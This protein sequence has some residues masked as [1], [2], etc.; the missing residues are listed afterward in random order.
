MQAKSR[1]ATLLGL[2]VILAPCAASAGGQGAAADRVRWLAEHAVAVRSIAPADED[3]SDLMPLLGWI[4][5]ARVVALGEVTHG[6]G[7][8]FLAKARLIRFLHQEMAFDVIAWESGFFDVPLVDAALR[9]DVPLPEAA[10]R[11]LYKIWANS[12]EV[13]PTFAYVR[14][15]QSTAHPIRSAGFDCRVSTERSRAALFPASIFDFFD[16]LD[17]GLISKQERADLVAMSVGL[18]P[19]DYYEHPGERRYN[20]ALPRRLVSVID[21][22]RA[23]LLVR[24]SP[25]QIDSVRQSLVSFMNMDRALGGLA[26][27]GH[28]DNGYTRDRAMAENLLWL[29]DGPL[30]GHKVIV[31]AHNYHVLRDLPMAGASEELTKTGS[32]AGPMGMHL[33][34]ALGR[35]FYVIG[36]AAHHGRYGY[37]GEKPVDLPAVDAD[38]FEG[39]L[40]AVGKPWLLLDLHGLPPDH[41][42]NGPLSSGFYFYEPQTTNMPRLY[43][44]VFFLDEMTPS[45]AVGT[46]DH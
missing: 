43:D 21:A 17:P 10:S 20:R 34:R 25:R 45:T 38:S 5:N 24:Y 46:P 26:G 3:F 23:E 19:A 6:D 14:A 15:T 13:Q 30:S 7:S 22:R 31:W 16:R 35:D 9:S 11:G 41:W 4:G 32:L 27:T 18:L 44:A 2:L 37:A 33:S 28:G 36:F 1:R 42:L 40:H 39:L 8:A 29:L 12:V